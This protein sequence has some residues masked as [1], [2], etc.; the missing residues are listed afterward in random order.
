LYLPLSNTFSN[1]NCNIN[2]SIS[3]SFTF[4][5]IMCNMHQQT[6]TFRRKYTCRLNLIIDSQKL[7]FKMPMFISTTTLAWDKYLNCIIFPTHNVALVFTYEVPLTMEIV[8]NPCPWSNMA[9]YHHGRCV[10]WKNPPH[11]LLVNSK[12]MKVFSIIHRSR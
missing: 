7:L 8:Y 6:T 2:S 11:D 4:N 1:T 12:Y 3:T 9:W 5:I 10:H